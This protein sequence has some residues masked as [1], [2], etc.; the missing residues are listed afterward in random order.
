MPNLNTSII[1]DLPIKY[2]PLTEQR[3]IAAILD[4]AD[5]LRAKRR[6][7]LKQFDEMAQAA[8]IEMFG[9]PTKPG[10]RTHMRPFGAL[11]KI[12]LG[13]MLDQ[14]RQ[15]G[16]HSRPYLRNANVRWFWFDLSNVFE[17]DFDERDR[18]KY[19][20]RRGDL[21]ICEGGEPGRAAI[22]KG[23]LKDCYFQKALHRFRPNLQVV[24]SE[25]L[26]QFLWLMA[27]RGGLKDYIS[28]STIAHLTKEKLETLMVPLPP[29]QKQQTFKER[30]DAI[31]VLRTKYVE[32]ATAAESLF[33]SL[34]HHAF[35]GEL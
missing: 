32:A 21:L 2:P 18:E 27:S 4:L 29:V 10:D 17:M 35:R 23:E 12:Q 3:R 7:A 9:D 20:L 13:K 24:L 15:T 11:G 33:A 19:S 8:F 5:A 26:A 34:Q 31:D 30:S 6:V 22:W 1:R 14:R 28:T 25:Y 16:T